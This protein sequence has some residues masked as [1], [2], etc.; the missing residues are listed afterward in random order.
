[1]STEIKTDTAAIEGC[2][3]SAG[4][5]AVPKAR[6]YSCGWCNGTGMVET[7]EHWKCAMC[8]GTGTRIIASR[9]HTPRI[10]R[11][12]GWRGAPTKLRSNQ[13]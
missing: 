9:P 4:Y 6:E 3:P 12:K 8:E 1:M 11:R 5:V 13:T 7:D 10:R 2:A